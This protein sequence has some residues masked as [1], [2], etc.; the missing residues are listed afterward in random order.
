MKYVN[1]CRVLPD[2]LVKELQNY[3]QGEYLYIPIQED[4]HKSWGERSG[5]REEIQQRNLKMI[6]EHQN[7]ASLERLAE[8]FCLSVSAVRKIIYQK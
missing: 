5:Y 2:S 4:C 3:V 6:A 1:A 8:M 7:G